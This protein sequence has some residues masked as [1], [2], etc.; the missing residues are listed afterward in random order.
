MTGPA[1][2][3]CDVTPVILA[4]GLGTRLRSVIADRPKAMAEVAGHPFLFYV[5]RRLEAAGC[6]T[7]VLCI[8]HLGAQIQ[9]AFGDGFGAMRLSYAVEHALLGTGGALHNALPLIA[10]D[11][12]LAM[13]GDS[14]CEAD[15]PTFLD[16]HRSR[17]AALSLLLTEVA[18]SGRYGRVDLGEHGA[19]TRFRE[20]EPG[21]GAGLINA[22]LYLTSRDRLAAIPADTVVSLERDVFPGLIGH[23]LYGW[24][25][26]GRFLDIGTRESYGEAAAFFSALGTTPSR[27]SLPEPATALHVT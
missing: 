26:G 8:G 7:A 17:P 20:K 2:S 24:T 16:W 15:L 21:S 27:R 9:A 1:R 13:N 22:G 5:L 25:G 14:W 4:G 6:R 10:T 19:V 12:V 11:T 18:D 23:G 3:L